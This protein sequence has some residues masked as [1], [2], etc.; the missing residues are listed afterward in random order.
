MSERVN[1][2]F[3]QAEIKFA[4]GY[5]YVGGMINVVPVSLQEDLKIYR[6]DMQGRPDAKVFGSPWWFGFSACDSLRKLAK[7]GGRS[8]REEARARLAIVTDEHGNVE[9]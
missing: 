5:P 1:E 6:F 8:L 9:N 7:A 2:R 4:R 3:M